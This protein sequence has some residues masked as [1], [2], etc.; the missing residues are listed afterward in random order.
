MH[1]NVR[2]YRPEWMTMPTTS[3]PTP[4]RSG[5]PPPLPIDKRA[6]AAELA[7]LQKGA[8]ERGNPACFQVDACENCSACQFCQGC[9][10]CHRC[11]YT[12]KSTGC[13][14]CTHVERSTQCHQSS[15]LT[16]CVRCLESHY[17]VHCHDCAECTYCFGC[18]GLVRQEFHILNEPYDRKTYFAKVKALK[19]ELGLS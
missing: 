10:D 11:S 14:H 16:D 12:T 2:P 18:V 13:T 8:S 15:H 3:P 9:R 6:F 7:R 5:A 4:P 17:L 19:A 1:V